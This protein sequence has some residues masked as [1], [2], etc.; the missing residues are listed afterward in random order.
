MAPARDACTIHE[1][2]PEEENHILQNLHKNVTFLEP[3]SNRDF[4]K[5]RKSYAPRFG[6]LKGPGRYFWFWGFAVC[7]HDYKSMLSI[8]FNL[9]KL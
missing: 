7:Y 5:P 3:I 6:V 2:D 8:A 1:S 9:E 4:S